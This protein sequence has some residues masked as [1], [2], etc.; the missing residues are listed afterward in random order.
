MLEDRKTIVKMLE[1]QFLDKPIF[2]AGR[3][4]WGRYIAKPN[5]FTGYT[6]CSRSSKN[7]LVD[8]LKPVSLADQGEMMEYVRELKRMEKGR[9]P[10]RG[11]SPQVCVTN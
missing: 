6:L 4:G 7:K 1:P 2:V 5:H 11:R 8:L 3:G 10:Y 9:A